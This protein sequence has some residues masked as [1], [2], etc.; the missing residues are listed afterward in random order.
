[1]TT[2]PMNAAPHGQPP[3]LHG[4]AQDD[5]VYSEVVREGVCKLEAYVEEM[6]TG[7]ST[8][9][10]FNIEKVQED[11]LEGCKIATQDQSRAEESHQGSL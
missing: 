8:P 7:D 1:M 10:A 4:T 2:S 9:T 6:A 3:H 11:V 5:I